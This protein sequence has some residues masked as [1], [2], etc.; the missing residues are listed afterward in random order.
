MNAP[1]D[2]QSG[3][4]QPDGKATASCTPATDAEAT[5]YRAALVWTP[6]GK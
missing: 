3:E 4:M 1:R 5:N 2:P 6:P